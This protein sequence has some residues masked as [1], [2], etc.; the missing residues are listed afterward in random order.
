ME[1]RRK[2][3]MSERVKLFP[4]KSDLV[5]PKKTRKTRRKPVAKTS[6][7]K[8]KLPK[9]KVTARKQKKRRKPGS[10]R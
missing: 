5:K 6:K 1:E 7:P 8:K 4:M 10:S 3:T 9:K 2:V